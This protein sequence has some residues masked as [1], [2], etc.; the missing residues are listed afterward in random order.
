MGGGDLKIGAKAREGERIIGNLFDTFR[1]MLMT[2][3]TFPLFDRV[4][5]ILMSEVNEGIFM[6]TP[7]A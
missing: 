1:D 4:V 3:L 2:A 6:T 7:S 5:L